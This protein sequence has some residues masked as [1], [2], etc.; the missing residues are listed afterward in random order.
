MKNRCKCKC[1]A[2]HTQ[3]NFVGLSVFLSILH[4]LFLVHDG[5]QLVTK[6]NQ[7]DTLFKGG[8]IDGAQTINGGP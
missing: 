3:Y 1:M 8:N 4:Q 6:S 2:R 5:G 7:V